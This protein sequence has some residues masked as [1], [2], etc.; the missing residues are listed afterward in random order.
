MDHSELL[1]PWYGKTFQTIRAM[2]HFTRESDDSHLARTPE[3]LAS[4]STDG[5]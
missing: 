1:G 5:T 4:G 2:L 3:V